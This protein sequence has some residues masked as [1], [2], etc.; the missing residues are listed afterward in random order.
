MAEKSKDHTEI[1]PQSDCG[2]KGAFIGEHAGI[3]HAAIY[4]PVSSYR[5]KQSTNQNKM[6]TSSAGMAEGHPSQDRLRKSFPRN[7]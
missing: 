2:K 6:E 1:T 3:A 5:T 4:S 7:V